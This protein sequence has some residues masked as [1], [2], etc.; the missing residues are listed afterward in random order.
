M[1]PEAADANYPQRRGLHCI[2]MDDGPRDPPI[3]TTGRLFW[4]LA[5]EAACI[6]LTPGAIRVDGRAAVALLLPAR[7]ESG[8]SGS[9]RGGRMPGNSANTQSDSSATSFRKDGVM[10]RTWCEQMISRCMYS[11]RWKGVELVYCFNN[12]TPMDAV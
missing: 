6:L 11:K 3:N 5:S 8:S 1:K 12:N 9:S 4:D 2:C 7:A 10:S